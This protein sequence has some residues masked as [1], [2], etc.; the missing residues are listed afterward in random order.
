MTTLTTRIR[1]DQELT[2]ILDEHSSKEVREKIVE[3]G[4]AWVHAGLLVLQGALTYTTNA[5]VNPGQAAPKFWDILRFCFGF[6]EKDGKSRAY[7]MELN[8]ILAVL[9]KTW[10]GMSR[11]LTLADISQMPGLATL[12]LKIACGE[13]W[14]SPHDKLAG[15]VYAGPLEMAGK[16]IESIRSTIQSRP[17]TRVQKTDLSGPI[18]LNFNRLL[19]GKPRYAVITLIHEG[20]HKFAGTTDS[21][22]FPDGESPALALDGMLDRCKA[23]AGNN[24]PFQEILNEAKRMMLQFSGG[25]GRAI[26]NLQK[27]LPEKAMN[28]ADSYANFAADVSDLQLDKEIDE[29]LAQTVRSL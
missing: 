28:N 4:S 9:N 10:I 14:T 21:Q 25:M 2:F 18:H 29:I 19:K 17:P 24:K 23:F 27:M 20:T 3:E 1:Q 8:E 12:Q 26:T 22:Y 7:M 15:L 11:D 5:L 13:L 6:P 16:Y